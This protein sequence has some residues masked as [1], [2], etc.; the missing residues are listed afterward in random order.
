M[1]LFAR[2][3]CLLL[4]GLLV[5]CE[6]GPGFTPL[7]AGSVVLALG[8]S[9]THG[10]GAGPGEDYPTHLAALSDWQVINAGVPGDTAQAARQRL[11]GLLHAHQPALVIV[12][13][14]GNDLLRKR[15]EDA[16]REDLRKLLEAV[17]MQGATPVLVAAPAVSMLRAGMGAL[18][19]ASLYRELAQDTDVL[20][21][22]GALSDILSKE[23]LRADPIHPNAEGYRR[24]ASDIAAALSE[25]GLL[26]E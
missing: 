2:M 4:A 3:L 6:Q 18:R 21:V 25:A 19:D 10:T 22:A 8:D 26:Q 24:L 20:L 9:V 17:R 15:P 13:L 11:P 14:G 5:A 7:P 12:E 1:T 16:I 23:A